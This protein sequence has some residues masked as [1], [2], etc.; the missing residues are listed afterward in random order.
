MCSNP[1]DFDKK[2]GDIEKSQTI[3]DVINRDNKQ[4]NRRDVIHQLQE[5]D[6]KTRQG[7]L[8]T[9]NSKKSNVND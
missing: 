4:C 6:K 2:K 5:A 1:D 7:L 3:E 8:E 9:D